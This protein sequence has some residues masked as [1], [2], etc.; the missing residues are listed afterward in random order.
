MKEIIEILNETV[1][2][3]DFSNEKHLISDGI[4]TSFEILMIISAL[5]SKFNVDITA[6]EILP[7]NFETVENIKNLI[8]RLK[9][10]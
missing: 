2:G 3:V 6:A 1:P 7:E 8:D 9:K 10:Q 5:N 4:I